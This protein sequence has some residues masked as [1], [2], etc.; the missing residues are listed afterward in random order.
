MDA[1]KFVTVFLKTVEIVPD[2]EESQ[3]PRGARKPVAV[4]GCFD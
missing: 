4:Q 2:T 3:V 1:W